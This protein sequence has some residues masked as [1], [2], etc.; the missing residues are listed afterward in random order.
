MGLRAES[1]LWPEEAEVLEVLSEVRDLTELKE[2]SSGG[3]GLGLDRPTGTTDAVWL[4]SEQEGGTQIQS[5]VENDYIHIT[6]V[7]DSVKAQNA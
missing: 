7:C 4:H 3:G 5:T 2:R 6:S 1:S